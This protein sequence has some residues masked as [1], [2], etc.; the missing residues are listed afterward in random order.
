[1]L[2]LPVQIALE[3]VC[4]GDAR[5]AG[6]FLRVRSVRFFLTPNG[7]SVLFFFLEAFPSL[8]K[9]R[10]LGFSEAS[11]SYSAIDSLVL[12]VFE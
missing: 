4:I 2:N 6:G 3:S 9:N 7:P 10:V 8:F 12:P 5:I 1:M 11:F